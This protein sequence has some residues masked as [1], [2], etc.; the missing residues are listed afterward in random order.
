MF[1]IS[2]PSMIVAILLSISFSL[3]ASKKFVFEEMRQ[4]AAVFSEN[5]PSD[6]VVYGVGEPVL[7]RAL[8]NDKFNGLVGVVVSDK[9]ESGRYQV[10]ILKYPKLNLHSLERPFQTIAVKPENMT[11]VGNANARLQSNL[12]NLFTELAFLLKKPESKTTQEY[13][14]A[15]LNPKDELGIQVRVIGW[16]LLHHLGTAA[17]SVVLEQHFPYVETS[18]GSSRVIETAWDGIGDW[19]A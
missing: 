15:L 2:V 7:L 14:K 16:F 4:Q 10:C 9:Q 17:M 3:Q 1:R 5:H 12:A 6:K 11:S 8:K 19:Q 18:K 13:Q